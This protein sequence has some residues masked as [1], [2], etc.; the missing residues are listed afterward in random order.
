VTKGCVVDVA[1]ITKNFND[2]RAL[3]ELVL[4]IEEGIFGLIG[5]NGAGK[6]TLIRILLGLIKPDSGSAQ[7]L[8]IDISESIKIREHIGILHEH[9]SLPK[10]MTAREYLPSVIKI[11]GSGKDPRDLLELVGLTDA[12]DRQIGH[13]SAGMQQRLGIAL[14][15]AGEPELIVLDE[16]TANLDVFGREQILSLV[17]RLHHESGVSFIISSHIIS[18]LE[19]VCTHIA[20]MDKGRAIVQGATND[21]IDRYAN[22]RYRIRCSDSYALAARLENISGL[23]QVHIVG[24]KLISFLLKSDLN[25]VTV[26]IEQEAASCDVQ[27]SKIEEAATLSDAFWEVIP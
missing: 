24:P 17:S 16:P 20:L 4:G 18:E 14:A 12:G 2:V 6:T 1:K 9:A 13:L 10:F 3:D 25:A 15:F 8:G 5:P 19:Q 22:N 23:D 27:V 26:R 7:V 11:Y 21:I